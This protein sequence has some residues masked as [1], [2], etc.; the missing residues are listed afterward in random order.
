MIEL[1]ANYMH[2][3]LLV[4]LYTN[5]QS[6]NLLLQC[7]KTKITKQLIPATVTYNK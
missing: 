5:T 6:I 3:N 2:N 1:L 7:Q 4:I